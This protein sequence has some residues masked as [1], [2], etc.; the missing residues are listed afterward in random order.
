M[1]L[2][3]AHF[4]LI[5]DSSLYST[6]IRRVTHA[7]VHEIKRQIMMWSKKESS[8]KNRKEETLACL[9]GTQECEVAQSELRRQQAR[10]NKSLNQIY[11][12]TSIKILVGFLRFPKILYVVLNLMEMCTE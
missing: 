6:F 4:V 5:M 12:T 7:G 3:T 8:Q 11:S 9:Q 2:I 1:G 10:I